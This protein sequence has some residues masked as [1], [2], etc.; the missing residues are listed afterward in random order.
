MCR[1]WRMARAVGREAHATSRLRGPDKKHSFRSLVMR[2]RRAVVF[3]FA[4]SAMV[5]GVSLHAQ[6]LG[7]I[8]GRVT[9]PTGEGLTGASVSAT[10]TQ[11]LAIVRSDGS[12][13]LSL[14]DGRYE[15]RVRLIGYG[16]AADSVTVPGSSVTKEFSIER[17]RPTLDNA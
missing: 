17:I 11:R 14:P 8:K 15:I 3:S 10:G 6:T 5:T 13:Q 16:T 7:I 12:Y 9:G 2:H 4:L 1:T